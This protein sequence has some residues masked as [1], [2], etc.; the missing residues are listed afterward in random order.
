MMIKILK[1]IEGGVN[2]GYNG[3]KII[4]KHCKHEI[5]SKQHKY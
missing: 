4:F 1:T 3:D 5:S 2:E